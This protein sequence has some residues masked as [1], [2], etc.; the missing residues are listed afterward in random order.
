[1]SEII[2]TAADAV[3]WL[4]ID[5]DWGEPRLKLVCTAARGAYCRKRHPDPDVEEW[6]PGDPGLI[7][8][9]RCWAVE[10]AEDAGWESVQVEEGAEF[11]PIPVSVTC[12]EGPML[13]PILPHPTLPE[14][15]R[16]K[17]SR[18]DVAREIALGDDPTCPWPDGFTRMEE[19]RAYRQADA[20]LALLP[21]RA[22]EEV[23]AEALEEAASVYDVAQ[24]SGVFFGAAEYPKAWLRARAAS[25]RGESHV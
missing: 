17:P 2:T 3:H 19:A 18:E 12:D 6:L 9:D 15:E 14:P 24:I 7:D 21:G 1:M 25:L 13:A 20:V 4:A 10:W 5:A 8:T 11:P 16:V 22:V 23:K